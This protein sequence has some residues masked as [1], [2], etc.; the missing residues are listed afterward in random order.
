M[1]QAA[2][3]A[4]GTDAVRLICSTKLFPWPIKVDGNHLEVLSPSSTERFPIAPLF[5]VS[6][7]SALAVATRQDGKTSL[8]DRQIFLGWDRDRALRFAMSSK[9]GGFP[10]LTAKGGK[11][12]AAGWFNGTLTGLRS[13]VPEEGDLSVFT[14]LLGKKVRKSF[15]EKNPGKVTESP[16]VTEEL[17]WFVLARERAYRPLRNEVNMWM[18]EVLEQNEP[19]ILPAP[20]LFNRGPRIQYRQ[21]TVAWAVRPGVPYAKEAV[22]YLSKS[23]E[24]A[25]RHPDRQGGFLD[26]GTPVFRASQLQDAMRSITSPWNNGPSWRLQA[27]TTMAL[28]L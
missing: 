13:V 25:A 2:A 8:T 16:V 17:L 24:T 5:R 22:E 1:T 11:L 7:C 10:L 26:D 21:S 20:V 6:G 19:F 27:L 15:F 28:P 18:N 12:E 4:P 23:F 14:H 9:P 3:H